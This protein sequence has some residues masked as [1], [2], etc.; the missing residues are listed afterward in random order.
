M[1]INSTI[2][3]ICV[4]GDSITW[5]A[6]DYEK[7]GWVERLKTDLLEHSDINVYNFGVCGN[8]TVDLLA[9]FDMES[10]IMKPEVIIFAIGINDSRYLKDPLV[11]EVNIKDFE[12]NI[13]ALINR[14]RKQTSRLAFVGLTPVDET[15]TTPRIHRENTKY[16]KNKIIQNYNSVIVSVCKREEIQFID[17]SN[18]LKD[19]DLEDG[20]HPTSNGHRII[21]DKVKPVVE[22]LIR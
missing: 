15:K 14:A 21:F 5:G 17:L 8:T 7:G 6:C 20:L 4:F 1:N 11:S 19:S 13:Q 9:C 22:S 12:S 10:E 18:L 16:Y 3:R 2:K